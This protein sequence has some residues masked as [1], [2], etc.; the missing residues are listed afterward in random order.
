[1]EKEKPINKQTQAISNDIGQLAEDARALVAATSDVAG[2]KVVEAR[3]R[4]AAVLESGK[5]AYGRA[6]EKAVEGVKAADEVM[7]HHPY[8]AIG[9][10]FGVGALI[11]YLVTRRYSCNGESC[12]TKN[13]CDHVT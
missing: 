10:A 4:L 11:G 6:R 7:H 3:K 5:E 12:S 1:M 13:D 8:Q 9:I 2:E